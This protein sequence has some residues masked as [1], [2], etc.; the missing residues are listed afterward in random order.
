[1]IFSHPLPMNKKPN[2][3]FVVC[4][5]MTVALTGMYGHPVVKTPH[6]NRLAQ[7]GIRFDAAYSPIP[8]C[9]PARACLVSGRYG[10]D[11]GIYDNGSCLA[12]DIPCMPHYLTNADYD[13]VLSGKMH[14]IGPDQ[15]HGF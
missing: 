1:P 5:Q 9:A 14:F 15:L 7:E 8:I 12:S 13:C 3:L 11:I 2:I 10:S 4:D 6:L